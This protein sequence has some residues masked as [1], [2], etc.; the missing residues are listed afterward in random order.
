[1]MLLLFSLL[2][3]TAFATDLG[4]WS[5][6]QLEATATSLLSPES[7]LVGAAGVPLQRA[8]A[9][10][11]VI[12]AQYRQGA[13]THVQA[14]PLFERGG[15]ELVS[16]GWGVG[17]CDRAAVLGVLDLG[18]H[19]RLSFADGW[20]AAEPQEPAAAPAHPVLAILS[21]DRDE[22]G[23]DRTEL[24]LL[25]LRDP[26]KPW[27]LLRARA[28]AHYPVW[29]PHAG[30]P[31]QRSLGQEALGLAILQGEQGPELQLTLRELPT[32][33]SRC[34]EPVP[35]LRRF[36]FEEGRFV[37]RYDGALHEPCP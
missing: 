4:D 23:G 13:F 6:A 33:D 35:E 29:D 37:E 14:M 27:Q 31:V 18:G 25:D 21:L 9:T 20:A 3:L 36:L 5:Q 32:P 11:G 1:M 15:Q 28:G 34:L 2:G 24:L 30:M 19:G 7:T 22:D 8:G 10:R 16:S 26:E 12:L 17:G